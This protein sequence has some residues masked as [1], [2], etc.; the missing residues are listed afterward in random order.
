M[1]KEDQILLQL[2][3]LERESKATRGLVMVLLALVS[4]FMLLNLFS[5]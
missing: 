3:A 2:Q 1:N 4:M 5:S